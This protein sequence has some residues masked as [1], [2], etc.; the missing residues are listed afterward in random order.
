MVRSQAQLATANVAV[1]TS[2]SDW[3]FTVAADYEDGPCRQAYCTGSDVCI[4]QTNSCLTPTTGCAMD[5][6]SDAGSTEMCV[7]NNGTPM[8]GTPISS[9]F[10]DIYPNAYADY[11]SLANGPSGLGMVVY[12]RIHGN[13]LGVTQ[14]KGTWSTTI[15]D[16]ETGSRA[17]NS[18]PDGG[19]SAVDTGD[20]GVGAS[21]FIDTQGDWHVSYVNG[22][23]ETLQ[24]IMVPGGTNPTNKP[25]VVDDGTSLNGQAFP[26][27]LHI[28]GDD[29]F[30]AVDSSGNVTISYQDAT[31]GTLRVAKG[32][33]MS[34][35]GGTHT[36]AQS[37]VSQPNLFAG[38]FS[39]FI[40]GQ[41]QI[42]NWWRASDPT[43]GS[44]SGNV[45][46]V[47]SP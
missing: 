25:E 19:I 2:M 37:A 13:L 8:C 38:F 21:L 47:A 26:D 35:A 5:C 46:F 39:H 44:I 6:G 22:S 16:G 36:W 41:T 3:T 10:L 14:S 20:V 42:A 45:A 15:F 11:I 17:P 1:P 31:V 7:S 24:Y 43:S 4:T 23:L 34:G 18:G 27:G 29:S 30:V 40:P 28:V 9:S 32:T 12:D 33:P